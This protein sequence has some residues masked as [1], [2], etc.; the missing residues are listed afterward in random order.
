MDVRKENRRIGSGQLVK[1]LYPELTCTTLNQAIDQAKRS[2]GVRQNHHAA[3]R[4][5]LKEQQS[6]ADQVSVLD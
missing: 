3:G 6:S 4:C 5:L 2:A 1:L